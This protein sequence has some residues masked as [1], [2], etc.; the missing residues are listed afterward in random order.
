[1]E[2]FLFFRFES[3]MSANKW[4]G[5]MVDLNWCR[6]N[7]WR[8]I[9]VQRERYAEPNLKLVSKQFNICRILLSYFREYWA[10]M[11]FCF[12]WLLW[13]SMTTVLLEKVIFCCWEVLVS[14]HM[15]AIHGLISSLFGSVKSSSALQW[16][17]ILPYLLWIVCRCFTNS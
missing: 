2:S 1:M 11:H 9:L 4:S 16:R 3:F 13:C 10:H 12:L 5:F 8:F 14:F 15:L 6:G 7:W 17:E